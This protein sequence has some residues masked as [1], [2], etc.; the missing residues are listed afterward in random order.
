MG[1]SAASCHHN[2][3]LKKKKKDRMIVHEISIPKGVNTFYDYCNPKSKIP[4]PTELL[5]HTFKEPSL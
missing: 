3:S 5:L 2:S 4:F 1:A